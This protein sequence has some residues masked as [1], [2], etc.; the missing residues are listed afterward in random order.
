VV[1]TLGAASPE[2]LQ[3]ANLGEH[4]AGTLVEADHRQKRIVR[5]FVE[6]QDRLHAPY[7]R[8]ARPHLVKGWVIA[9]KKQLVF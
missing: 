4:L 1:A 6:V 7:E 9:P 8:R 2:G 3:L 5:L